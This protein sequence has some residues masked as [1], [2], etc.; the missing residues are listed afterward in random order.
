LRKQVTQDLEIDRMGINEEA[1][2]ASVRGHDRMT[3][4]KCVEPS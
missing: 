1:H 2:R 4:A 3:A